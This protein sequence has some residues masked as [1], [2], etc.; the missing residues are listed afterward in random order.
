MLLCPIFS[1]WFLIGKPIRVSYYLLS[2]NRNQQYTKIDLCESQ[3]Q[4][5]FRPLHSLCIFQMVIVASLV[6]HRT[7]FVGD[8]RNFDHQQ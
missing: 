2:V 7:T 3:G 5:P 6:V 8:I 4:K 1:D